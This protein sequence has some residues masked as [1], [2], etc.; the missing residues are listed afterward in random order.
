[1]QKS[2]PFLAR[3]LIAS[4]IIHWTNDVLDKPPKKCVKRSQVLMR[5][6][7]KLTA[8]IARVG[9]SL[10]IQLGLCPWNVL[11]YWPNQS[12]IQCSMSN[13]T[14]LTKTSKKHQLGI[15]KRKIPTVSN[16]GQIK[17]S[18]V[19]RCTEYGGGQADTDRGT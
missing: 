1:M 10:S 19:G 7:T 8:I 13:L 4:S 15:V 17:N 12:V 2:V 5:S 16:Q 6:G 11:L 18:W 3:Q 9:A 14:C